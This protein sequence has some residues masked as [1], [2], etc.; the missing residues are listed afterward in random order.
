MKRVLVIKPSSLGD[1]IHGLQV[2]ETLRQQIPGVEIDW[3]ARDIFAPL[4]RSCA[5][6]NRVL[7]FHRRG[8][9]SPF[10]TLI[11]E[12][13]Q[14]RYDLVL[15]LQGLARSS[16]L[17]L[18]ACGQ[19]KIGRG[20]GREGS[21]WLI[22]EKAPLPVGWP[23]V[24]AV[25]ILLQF[26]LPLGLEPKLQGKLRFH[27]DPTIPT[28][29]TPF[30]VS[31]NTILLFPDSRRPEKEWPHFAALTALLLENF[32]EKN[33]LWLGQGKDAANPAW[34]PSRFADLQGKTSLPEVAHLIGLA[35]LVICNDSGPLHI[36]AA[37][38]TPVLGIFGPTDPHRYGP[39]PLDNPQN[40]FLQAPNGDL[41]SLTAQAVAAHV[42]NSIFNSKEN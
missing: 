8:G 40:H 9:L 35:G 11:Q 33:V 25:E 16:V 15:D 39:Y 41:P 19:R 10:R 21:R 2:V 26:L 32:P 36:A 1:I 42:T 27:L 23:Q 4:V 34:S 30:P 29:S 12:I 7:E 3:V 18:A 22:R 17:T 20:D 6:V 38:G 13:R 5:T 31:T 37:T 14:T 24:H 28:A